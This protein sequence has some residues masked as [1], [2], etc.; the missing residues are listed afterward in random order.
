MKSSRARM[1]VIATVALASAAT[2]GVASAATAAEVTTYPF[3][4]LP[5]LTI[6]S[7]YPNY[8]LEVDCDTWV[9]SDGDDDSEYGELDLAWVPGGSLDVSF[10]CETSDDGSDPLDE[11]LDGG[12]FPDGYVMSAGTGDF[13]ETF[14]VDP[15]TRLTVQLPE[16]LFVVNYYASLEVD[17]P[18][19]ALVLTE[20]VST[21]ADGEQSVDFA[22]GEG[23]D[24]FVC[25][26]EGKRVY[27]IV[28]FTVLEGGEF[29][30]R[31]VD[32]SP[33][34]SGEL[35]TEDDYTS[36]W[37]Y[38]PNPWGDY[39]PIADPYLVLFT[40]FDPDAP[41]AGQIDCNDDG[42]FF[43]ADA[44][45]YVHDSQGRHLSG[46]YSELA[47][48]L[49]PGQYTLL[50]TTYDEVESLDEAAAPAKA[51]S[52]SATL[53][54]AAYELDGLPEQSATIEFWGVEDG[55]VL[56]HTAELADTGADQSVQTGLAL[57]AV[58]ALLLGALSIAVVRRRSA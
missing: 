22:D 21:P 38:S 41:N 10:T 54:S 44:S 24:D 58:L 49:E 52:A 56:G 14:S 35:M 31:V 45:A 20:D 30:F 23:D 3:E 57:G 17:D 1:K 9:Y 55:L 5:G 28:E 7:P 12:E 48:E 8:E 43:E 11:T 40:S 33:L 2:L 25:G 16:Q 32:V 37:T 53:N 18:S 15:N 50:L 47:V 46:V 34:Q 6:S 39:V 26:I 4:F 36:W 19:G 29:T 51:E 27:G 42:E 13:A